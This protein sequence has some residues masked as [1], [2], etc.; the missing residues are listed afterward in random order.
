[1]ARDQWRGATA[2]RGTPRFGLGGQVD[3]TRGPPNGPPSESATEGTRS[4]IV[5]VRGSGA[6]LRGSGGRRPSDRCRQPKSCVSYKPPKEDDAPEVIPGSG[7]E[8]ELT[9]VVVLVTGATDLVPE[10]AAELAAPV[11]CSAAAPAAPRVLEA[12]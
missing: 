2:R 12:V 10:L 1:M 11:A 7:D 4:A 5:P 3:R 8:A 9:G 6:P